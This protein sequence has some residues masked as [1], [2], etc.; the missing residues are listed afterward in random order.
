[1]SDPA[2]HS[3][4]DPA[5]SVKYDQLVCFIRFSAKIDPHVACIPTWPQSVLRASMCL[6]R[7]TTSPPASLHLVS[8]ESP[9]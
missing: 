1:M 5:C 4:G 3:W 7:A 2:F 9:P 6:P 8:F